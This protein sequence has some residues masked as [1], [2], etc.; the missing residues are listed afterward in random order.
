VGFLS[1]LEVIM[2]SLKLCGFVPAVLSP[3]K[4]PQPILGAV[5]PISQ[6]FEKERLLIICETNDPNI[7]QDKKEEIEKKS[8]GQNR[9]HISYKKHI[10][11]NGEEM[12][13]YHRKGGYFTDMAH[14]M[15][16]QLDNVLSWHGRALVLR[17]D[18]KQDY[19]IDNSTEVSK[20]RKALNKH[21]SSQ[22]GISK[23]GYVWSREHETAKGQHYHFA[24]F[25]DG[26]AIRHP[27]ALCDK[28]IEIWTRNKCGTHNVWMPKRRY[29]FVDDDEI[30]AKA[31]YRISYLTKGNSRTD[32]PPQ[33][34]DYGMSRLKPKQIE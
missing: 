8:S 24:L 6:V 27:G 7:N 2:G 33:A 12:R 5:E 31:I 13:F 29:Y 34:K 9:K 28:I 11:H 10:V 21:L 1:D 16:D 18:L 25:L 22:Y 14:K 20:F 19:E 26:N 17:F 4:I 23:T 3:S 15:I 32:R 30:R